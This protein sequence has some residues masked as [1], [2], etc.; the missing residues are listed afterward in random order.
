[1]MKLVSRM[2]QWMFPPAHLRVVLAG[3]RYV[4]RVVPFGVA[5]QLVPALIR[6]S[7]AIGDGRIDDDAVYADVVTVLHLGL[8]IPRWRISRLDCDLTELPAVFERVGIANGLVPKEGTGPV[9]KLL[10]ARIW[11]ARKSG[12]PLPA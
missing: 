8:G 12:T 9:G 10:A 7:Q 6:A 1:M 11:V 2:W 3:K 5:R 4:A